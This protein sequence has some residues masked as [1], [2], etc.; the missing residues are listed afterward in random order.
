MIFHSFLYVYQRVIINQQGW[1]AA[2][3]PVGA[4]PPPKIRRRDWHRPLRER[5]VSDEL[6]QFAA[7]RNGWR[8]DG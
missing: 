6:R 1:I 5:S 8:L 7:R 4:D 3:A 2:T